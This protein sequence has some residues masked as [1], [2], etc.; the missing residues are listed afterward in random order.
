MTRYD[1]DTSP[2]PQNWLQSDEGERI[3][4][5]T[6]YHRRQ[7][8]KLPNEQLHA[9][10]HVIVENQLALGE[11]VVVNVTGHATFGSSDAV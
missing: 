4:S 3:Q 6:T 2:A 8:I 10:I 7:R 9:V 5:V 1:P 11:Q